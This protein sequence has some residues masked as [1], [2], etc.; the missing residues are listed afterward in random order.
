MTWILRFPA[1][2]NGIAGSEQVT[3]ETRKPS[4]FE[5][6]RIKCV[7]YDWLNRW[8]KDSE[9]ACKIKNCPKWDSE[10]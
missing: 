1:G 3:A 5:S 4:E 8:C 7:A 6:F 10:S 9:K 2:G